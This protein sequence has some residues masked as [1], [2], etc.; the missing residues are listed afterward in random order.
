MVYNKGNMRRL[1]RKKIVFS[2]LLLRN[3]GKTE[4]KYGKVLKQRLLFSLF[5]LG[6]FVLSVMVKFRLGM[7]EA[8]CEHTLRKPYLVRY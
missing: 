7:F 5:I 2:S 4:C 8:V 6:L 1:E 3:F